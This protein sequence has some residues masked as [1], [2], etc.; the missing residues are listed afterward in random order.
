M[1][2]LGRNAT[3]VIPAALLFL[4]IE[5]S[6]AAGLRPWERY[7]MIPVSQACERPSSDQ[8]ALIDRAGR[9][10]QVWD[11]GNGLTVWAYCRGDL[12]VRREIFG[13]DGLLLQSQVAEGSE[14]HEILT[15]SWLCRGHSDE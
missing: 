13:I 11:L 3:V 4:A 2:R 10:D 7:D 1:T 14:Y 8:Q 6:C 15:S 12:T 9:P 5:I